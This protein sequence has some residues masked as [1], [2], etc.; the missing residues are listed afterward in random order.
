M[1]FQTPPAPFSLPAQ[2]PQTQHVGSRGL[3]RHKANA[4]V[5]SPN[6]DLGAIPKTPTRA[7]NKAPHLPSTGPAPALT[8]PHTISVPTCPGAATLSG[9]AA[10]CLFLLST[11]TIPATGSSDRAP[12]HLRYRGGSNSPVTRGQ[13]ACRLLTACPCSPAA[14]AGH[15]AP[16]TRA[17]RRRL[18]RQRST[19]CLYGIS[20]QSHGFLLFFFFRL[21]ISFPICFQ[22]FLQIPLA[23]L[24]GEDNRQLCRASLLHLTGFTGTTYW[25]LPVPT[26]QFSSPSPLPSLLLCFTYL[27]ENKRSQGFL[28]LH[29]DSVSFISHKCICRFLCFFI[30]SLRLQ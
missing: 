13:A 14:S 6:A 11:S 27:A 7:L 19:C 2:H 22:K 16:L 4:S 8:P 28:L 10:A 3:T 29:L 20:V 5:Q 21:P 18:C 17:D 26:L 15:P 9:T 25:G 30:C 24:R 12:H 1:A 23:Q